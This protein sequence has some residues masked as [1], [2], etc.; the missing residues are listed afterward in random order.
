MQFVRNLH[1]SVWGKIADVSW[2]ILEMV[3]GK[4][5]G[6]TIIELLVAIGILMVMAALSAPYLSALKGQLEASHDVR[7]LATVLGEM[8]AESL[9]LRTNVRLTFSGNEVSWDIDD[10]GTDEGS[11]IL[12][13]QSSWVDGDPGD[14]LFNGL[15]LARNLDAEETIGVKNRGQ[16]ISLTINKNGYVNL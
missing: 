10:D 16:S 15:G 9:R 7:A 1:T 11:Y 8:R 6:F 13:E 12:S 4:N 14:I 2:I 3:M 5:S